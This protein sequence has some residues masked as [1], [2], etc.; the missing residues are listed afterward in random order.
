VPGARVTAVA[1]KPSVSSDL[2]VEHLPIDKL[3]AV[4]AAFAKH[5]RGR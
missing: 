5:R 3:D 2:R 4:A 1:T